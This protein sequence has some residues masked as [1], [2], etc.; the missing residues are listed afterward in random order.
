MPS[1]A[2]VSSRVALLRLAPIFL[3]VS[4]RRRHRGPHPRDADLFAGERLEGLRVA[5][6]ELSWLLE[7]GYSPHAALELV[8]DRHALRSRQR[9]AVLRSSCGRSQLEARCA[10]S[11]AVRD[12]A[13]RHVAIDGFNVIITVEAALSGG[14]VL[15]GVDG[16]HRDLASVHGSYRKVEETQLAIELLGQLLD[17]A[18]QVSWFLDRPV[19]NSGRLKKT[20]ERLGDERG[21]AWS[22]ELVHT[23][24]RELRMLED[25]VVATSDGPLLD[26]VESWVD[27][28]AHLIETEIAPAWLVDLRPGDTVAET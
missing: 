8:G 16:V 6:L 1:H 2:G 17:E 22:V 10:R 3:D 24:D 25:A 13:G 21:R 27:L 18:S 11:V 9:L 23:P 12:L 14:V 19:S 15:V 28:P 7:R 20:I 4:D 26:R 5:T